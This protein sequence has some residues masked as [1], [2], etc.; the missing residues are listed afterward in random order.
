MSAPA[1]PSAPADR[2]AAF[3][4]APFLRYWIQRLLNTLAVQIVS[5]AVGWQIYETES[6]EL[7]AE[8][9]G[10]SQ[11]TLSRE[12]ARLEYLLGFELFDRV[13]GRLRPTARALAL[14]QEVE[15]SFVG[16]EQIA[17]RALALRSTR[18]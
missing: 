3:R 9:T 16:L 18:K 17:A 4:H 15:R 5:V 8:V 10:S 1:A 13:R 11:P 14:M 6:S 7:A 12:L 2:Y